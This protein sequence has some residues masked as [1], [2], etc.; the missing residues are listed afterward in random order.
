MIAAVESAF[1][2]ALEDFKAG[3]KK[4][5]QDNF[6]LTTLDDL[7]QEI[8]RL[9]AKHMS[10]RRGQNL[11]RLKPFIEAMNQIGQIV[12]LFSNSSEF[13]AFIWVGSQSSPGQLRRA[14]H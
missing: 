14:D 7:T 1:E 10:Q 11:A 13:V 4:K 9:Q 8:D 2:K 5:D 12:E 6:K 3:L